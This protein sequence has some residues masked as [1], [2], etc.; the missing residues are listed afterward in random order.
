[1]TQ[2]QHQ[3]VPTYAPLP[4]AVAVRPEGS[5]RF[6]GGAGSFFLV[7]LGASL[8]STVTLGLALPW[9]MCMYFRWQTEHTIVNGRRLRFT[10]TGGGLFGHYLKWWVLTVVTLGI[11]SFWVWPRMIRW[12]TERQDFGAQV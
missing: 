4:T 1:M 12:C 9:S 11:Y 6:D 7:G 8:L 5:F 3:P 2:Q 10:G